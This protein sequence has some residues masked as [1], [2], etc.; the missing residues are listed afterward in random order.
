MFPNLAA[1]TNGELLEKAI[2]QAT[3]YGR[4]WYLQLSPAERFQMRTQ[5][6]GTLINAVLKFDGEPTPRESILAVLELDQRARNAG[7]TDSGK[8]VRAQYQRLTGDTA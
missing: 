8:W 2:P 4:A 1:M 7:F 5:S 3:P 6:L